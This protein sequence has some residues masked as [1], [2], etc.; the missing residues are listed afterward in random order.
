[1][2]KKL[3]KIGNSRALVITK[4]MLEKLGITDTTQLRIRVD[5]DS[6]VITPVK[7][8]KAKPSIKHAKRIAKPSKI[9]TKISNDPKV[10][11]LFEEIIEE[12]GPA[13]K[14]LAKK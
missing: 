6:I 14:E 11:R 4:P 5:G 12:Y 1:M 13:F 2:V 8:A 10:Q 7:K 3:R 9:K